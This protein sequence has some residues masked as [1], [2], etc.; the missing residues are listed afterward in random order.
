MGACCFPNHFCLVLAQIDCA[1]AGGTWGGLGTDCADHN[2]NGTADFC[3][4]HCACDWNNS[5]GLN[6]QDFFD[7]LT[8]FFNGAADFNHDTFTNSQ[9]FFDFLGCFFSGC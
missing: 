8:S 2:S 4:P 9:D 5:G 3:E 7:F 6:S 1:N